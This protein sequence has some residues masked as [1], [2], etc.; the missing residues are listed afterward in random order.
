VIKKI[1]VGIGS[2]NITQNDNYVRAKGRRYGFESRQGINEYGKHSNAAAF[3]I[4]L[5]CIVCVLKKK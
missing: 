1:Q 2:K 4:D 3:I 5:I